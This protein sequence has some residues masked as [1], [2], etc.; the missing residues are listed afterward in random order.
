MQGYN[1]NWFAE[2][3]DAIVNK[4]VTDTITGTA[5]IT[6]LSKNMDEIMFMK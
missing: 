1:V 3:G 2:K 6:E 4:E 5:P